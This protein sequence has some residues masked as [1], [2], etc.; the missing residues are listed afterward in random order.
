VFMDLEKQGGGPLIDI[1]THALDLAL[2]TMNNY[3]PK[4]VVGSA[5][6]K[7][8]DKSEGNM[9]GPWNQDEFKVEDSAFG[10]IKMENGATITLEASWA[11]NMINGKEAQVT[12]CGTEAGAEMF[13]DAWDNR[14]TITFNTT[15]YGQQVETH[16][17]AGGGVAFFAGQT[18]GAG[19]LEAKQWIEAILEDKEP[20]VRPE[21]AFVVTQILEAIYK[22]SETGKA[23][24]L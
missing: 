10:F 24:E 18:L 11:L 17:S 4:L 14:G 1:G 22:S 12:L 23:V 21:Q 9:F 15:K 2:W 13:G 5:F 16:T 6:H 7:L 19:D 20:L 3:N 8:K